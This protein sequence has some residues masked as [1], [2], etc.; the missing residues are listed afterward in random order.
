MEP[1]SAGCMLWFIAVCRFY[2][3]P[4]NSSVI[5]VMPW[6]N[7]YR[8][9]PT[10]NPPGCCWGNRGL[11]GLPTLL[12]CG[13]SGLR[14]MMLQY[15]AIPFSFNDPK[16]HLSEAVLHIVCQKQHDFLW[17]WVTLGTILSTTI[18]SPRTQENT[19]MKKNSSKEREAVTGNDMFN[20]VN[21]FT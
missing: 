5:W 7:S 12:I 10:G 1:R 2:Y 14:D 15:G 21:T 8:E 4:Q 20:A 11:A 17:V 9:P 13:S 3:F 18:Y 16:Q 19:R 6:P